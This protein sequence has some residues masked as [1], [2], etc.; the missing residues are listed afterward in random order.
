MNSNLEREYKATE[1]EYLA[2]LAQTGVDG[3]I[4]EFDKIASEVNQKRDGT[5][6][7]RRL[8]VRNTG[9][10]RHLYEQAKLLEDGQ[11]SRPFETLAEVH[12]IR[13]EKWIPAPAF[14]DVED[15]IRQHLAF[16][17]AREYLEEQMGDPEMVEIRWKQP[18]G[19]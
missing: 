10:G 15:L 1:H 11:V 9:N 6:F 4:A 2:S 14:A 18:D 13:R 12:L 7:S 19:R 17:K 16:Q 8:R 5:F 3:N